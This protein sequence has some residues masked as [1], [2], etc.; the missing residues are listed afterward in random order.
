MRNGAGSVEGPLAQQ[1]ARHLPRYARA[2]LLILVSFLV[3]TLTS[4]T[5]ASSE[6]QQ[7]QWHP[8]VSSFAASAFPGNGG[9]T[10]IGLRKRHRE[11]PTTTQRSS[12][13]LCGMN[14]S[15]PG[16]ARRR[17][18]VATEAKDETDRLKQTADSTAAELKRSL[19]QERERA[20]Q[21]E[22][23]LAAA[24][25]ELETQTAVATKAKDEA[26]RLKPSAENSGS[27]LKAIANE[28]STAR[29]KVDTYDD[30]S[31][32]ASEQETK[33]SAA[34]D[35]VALR[36]SLQQARE[37]AEQ[38]ERNLLTSKKR[39][40]ETPALA[41]KAN[42]QAS[43]LKQLANSG[44]AE[45]QQSLQ[46]EH[47]RAEALAQELSTARAKISEYEAQARKATGQA[48]ELKKAAVEGGAVELGKSLQQ[49]RARAEQLEQNLAS[50]KHDLETQTALAARANDEANRLKQVADSGAAELK[51]SLRQEH[52]RAEELA[53]ELSTARAK[54]SEYEAQALRPDRTEELKKAAAVESGAVELRKTL[55]QERARAEELEQKLASAKNDIETKTALVAKANDEA[56]RLKQVAD[57]GA[58]E[59]KQAVR[60]ENERAD[61]ASAGALD[62]TRKVIRKRSPSSSS[63][64]NPQE[65]GGGGKRRGRVEKIPATGTRTG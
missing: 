34:E 64:R 14:A 36:T 26:G 57:S 18:A 33:K 31:R 22:R 65:C 12:E 47:E 49:E 4:E 42:D 52:E 3:A 9:N 24:R 32:K 44:A 63:G 20:S 60:Q 2:V 41:G 1:P 62:S 23:D 37:R 25:R 11:P 51:Q 30:E 16:A 46:Q 29:S 5:R 43:G 17:T 59:L 27:E 54:I 28:L 55:Q 7:A 8:F 6:W 58:A 13:T 35:G 38:L 56:S 10:P 61:G 40:V 15:K 50:A 53:Q 39:D 45:L 21:L 48:E 19:Q